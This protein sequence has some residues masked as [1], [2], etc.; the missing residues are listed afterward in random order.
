MRNEDD[1]WAGY[2]PDE[3]TRAV[4]KTAGSWT[5]VD[6]DCLLQAS[7]GLGTQ[8]AGT[9]RGSRAGGRGARN[10]QTA[11]A[12]ELY[13]AAELNRRGAY[14]V[15]FA[16]NMPGFDILASNVNRNRLVFLQVKTRRVGN[17]QTTVN[18]GRP[19]LEDPD[20]NEFWVFVD[21]WKHDD[22]PPDYYIVA[23]WWMRNN[24]FEVH[25]EYLKRHS[26]TRP[27]TQASLHHKIELPRVAH[28]SN[29][30]ERLGLF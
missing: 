26:G 27:R 17:W 6:A 25:Q 2:D 28:G 22:E 23:D 16:G 15:T 20:K 29:K 7:A 13:V 8:L 4:E 3:V 30:W 18:Q 9:L 10:Q 14:A 11:R 19:M 1:I 5:D 21:L 12:G 24:I